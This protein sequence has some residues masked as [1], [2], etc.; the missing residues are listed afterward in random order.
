MNEIHLFELQ[1]TENSVNAFKATKQNY[2]A[3][4]LD[5]PKPMRVDKRKINKWRKKKHWNRMQEKKEN[6]VQRIYTQM[7]FRAEVNKTSKRDESTIRFFSF[8]IYFVV[9]EKTASQK[10]KHIIS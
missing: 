8:Q 10:K 5:K 2:D 6:K 7:N 9:D 1:K 3:R 4:I